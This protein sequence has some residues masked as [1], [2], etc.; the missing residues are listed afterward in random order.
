[1]LHEEEVCYLQKQSGV[2]L[3]V[4][5]TK[6]EHAGHMTRMGEIRVYIILMEE[7]I[8][9]SL[10]LNGS[11]RKRREGNKRIEIKGLGLCFKN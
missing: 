5:D 4:E 8:W 6:L 7:I 10:R 1:M 9:K 11:L 3:A 2:V